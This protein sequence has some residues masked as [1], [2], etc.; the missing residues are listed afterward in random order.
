MK[1]TIENTFNALK[2][3]DATLLKLT[4]DRSSPGEHDGAV[5]TV[6]WPD[7]TRNDVLFSDAYLLEARMNF[8][9][10]APESIRDAQCRIDSPRLHEVRGRWQGLDVA[11]DDLREF[12]ITTSSTASTIRI[13]ARQFHV[14]PTEASAP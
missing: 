11:L 7:G 9:V 8:G 5:M 13:C 3:H 12:E 1:E 4:I 10:I 2:W 14:F 6:E